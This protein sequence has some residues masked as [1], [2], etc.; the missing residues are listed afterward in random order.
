[1]SAF[2]R[3]PQPLRPI[4]ATLTRFA[5]APTGW[6]HLGHVLNALH[7]WNT[8]RL[9]G[10]QVMLRIEDHDRERSRPEFERAILD[11]LDWLGFAPDVYPTAAFRSGPCQGRQ[12]DREEIYRA[13][14]QRLVRANVL[15]ACECTRRALTAASTSEPGHETRYPG[16]CREKRLPLIDGYGWRVRLD[17]AIEEFDD[18]LLGPQSQRPSAQ[19]GDLLIRDRIGNWTYQFS[20]AVDDLW[21]GVDLVIRGIDLLD[22][23]GRQIQLAR[24]LGR[25]VPA[26]FMHH[27]LIMKTR[28][29]KLSK[30]DGD[31]GVR[32]LAS[33]GWTRDRILAEAA[34]LSSFQAIAETDPQSWVPPR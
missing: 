1:M 13:A 10:S 2:P 14:V 17:D 34:R 26:I 33:A 22:S 19:C 28:T 12:S 9:A 27:P 11:D 32:A 8:A 6:L 25:Q 3:T 15:Y 4:K 21:Q 31:T 24:L 5:P 7:V 23:T 29:Q 20:A 30:S 16:T 18:G